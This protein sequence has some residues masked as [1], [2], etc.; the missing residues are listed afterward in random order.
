M[1]W[2]KLRVRIEGRWEQAD[3]QVTIRNHGSNDNPLTIS[4]DH[5]GQGPRIYSAG[6]N[7]EQYA[8]DSVSTRGGMLNRRP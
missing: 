1:A 3:T 7:Y 6:K 5:R 4:P 8:L 2:G